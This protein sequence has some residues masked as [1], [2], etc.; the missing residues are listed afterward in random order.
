MKGPKFREPRSFNWRQNFIHIMAS[1]EE[2]AKRW[3]KHEEEDHDTLSEWVKS[4]RCFLKSR[5]KRLRGQMK[6]VYPSVFNNTEVSSELSRLQSQYVLVPADKAGNNIV[7][8]CKAHYINC[9]LDELGFNSTS[10]NPTYTLS[11]LSK[12]EILQNHKSVLD[13]FNIP[14][15][16]DEFDLPYLYW[17]PKL[18]KS[19]YK[20]R[21]IAGSSKCSTKPL[22][23]LLTKILTI[24]KE[25]LQEYC[26][27]I[28]ARSGVN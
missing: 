10:G 9:I 25:K 26:A 24:V 7:F 22:S 17:I 28:Y 4:V 14:K 12:E 18:H 2:Y 15:Y 6:T 11:S 16:Q 3:A 27:T 23:I 5:I 21:Y 1:V 19:P 13:I 8:V 20:Q